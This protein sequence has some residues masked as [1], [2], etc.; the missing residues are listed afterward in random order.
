MNKKLFIAI[1]ALTGTVIGAGFLGIPY[2]IAKSGFL[3]GL[4]W[5]MLICGMMLIVNLAIGEIALSTKTIHHIPG[6]ASKYLGRKT[7]IFVFLVTIFGF[8]A[9]LVAYLLG[10]GESL[11]FLLTSSTS[12]SL[13]AGIVFWLVVAVISFGGIRRFKKIEPFAVL[14]VILVTILFFTS[15]I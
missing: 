5:M 1:A 4:I 11:S 3:I 8:Y 2:V 9:A 13:F 14:I 15:S 6:Y 7:K 10:E 12:Y